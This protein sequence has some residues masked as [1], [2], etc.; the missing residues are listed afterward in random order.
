MLRVGADVD[1]LTELLPALLLFSVGLSATVA[2]LTATVLADAD[3]E[4]AGIASG[5]NNAIARAAG[6]LGI[7]AIGAV[8]AAQFAGAL[9]DRIDPATLSPEGRS[10][11]RVAQDR[12]LARVD[13]SALPPEEGEQVAAAVE[14]ASVSAFHTGMIISAALVGLGGLLGIALVRTPRR[15]VCAEDCAG[16]QLV[17]APAEAVRERVPVPA[18]A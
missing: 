18:P 9:G 10:V 12:A 16:G 14:A 1:Y 17:A 15:Y 2:P 11:V 7:A 13:V 4:H 3:E 6:L 5:I 8:I